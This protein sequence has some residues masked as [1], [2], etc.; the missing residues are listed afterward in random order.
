MKRF[1]YTAIVAA[2]LLS[3]SAAFAQDA[4]RPGQPGFVLPAECLPAAIAANG[5]AGCL[6]LFEG[7]TIVEA[8]ALENAVAAANGGVQV[9]ALSDALDEAGLGAGPN[10]GPQAGGPTGPS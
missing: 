1:L 4:V 7:L 8:R 2:G 10:L 3:S 5:A 6:A 9:A